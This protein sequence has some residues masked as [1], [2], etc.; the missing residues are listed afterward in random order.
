MCFEPLPY[1]RRL[2][3]GPPARRT[4]WLTPPMS[5]SRRILSSLALRPALVRAS[6]AAL[7]NTANPVEAAMS[8]TSTNSIPNLC[9]ACPSRTSPWP[10]RIGRRRELPSSS[11][12]IPAASAASPRSQ[13]LRT[14]S[15][16]QKLTRSTWKCTSCLS[17]RGPRRGSTGP[18]GSGRSTIISSCLYSCGPGAARRTCPGSS[19]DDE[20]AGALRRALTRRRL[21]S[22]NLVPTSRE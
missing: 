10:R 20:V 8:V 4:P 14:S 15:S 18:A 17:A 11:T 2:P 12:P 5:I 13:W 9:L 3:R 6:S 1:D 16:S 19:R 22:M 21:T 7:V